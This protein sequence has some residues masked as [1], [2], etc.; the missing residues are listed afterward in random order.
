MIM[1]FVFYEDFLFQW[2]ILYLCLGFLFLLI[3][4][5]DRYVS[6]L[7]GRLGPFLF[8]A[9]AAALFYATKMQHDADDS[10]LVY[11][12]GTAATGYVVLAFYFLFNQKKRV[13][14]RSRRNRHIISM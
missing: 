6:P 4:I 9:E 14:K 1:A 11:A 5:L 10:T 3:G 7:L 12:A 2:E 8:F 13:K